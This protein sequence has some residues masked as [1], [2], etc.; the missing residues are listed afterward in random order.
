VKEYGLYI[1]DMD[2]V[3]FRGDTPV[4]GA[5]ETLDRLRSRG[6][7]VRF[8]TN[9]STKTRE[10]NARILREMGF[11]AQAEEVFTSAVA[12][13]RFLRSSTAWVLGEPGLFEELHEAGVKV[14]AHGDADWVVVGLQ[15]NLTYDQIDEAQWRIRSGARF[16][17]TNRDATYPVE[18]R[19]RP[20]AGMVVAAVAA[21]AEQ[22]P[23]IV[24]GKPEPT[25]V[26]MILDEV[27]ADP[28]EAL[29]IGDRLDTDIECARRACCDS[30]LV[31]T[32]VTEG[33]PEGVATLPTVAHLL[34]GAER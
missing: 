5:R 15:R 13:A 25:M 26:H 18:R 21:A 14:V 27:G 7:V 4:P 10:H 3:L 34:G 31:L 1:F 2:G 32:G 12:T 19:V 11:A 6:A 29:L 24:I 22:E 9:N 16:L 28:S 8:L 17:A 23:E 20:G 33:A 30:V